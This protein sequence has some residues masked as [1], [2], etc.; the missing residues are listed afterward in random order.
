MISNSENINTGQINADGDVI[1]GGQKVTNI[2]YSNQYKE[3]KSNHEK[4]DRDFEELQLQ[5]SSNPGIDYFTKRLVE[6]DA[7]RSKLQ[8]TITDFEN[9]ILKLAREFMRIPVNTERIKIARSHF[10]NGEYEKARKVLDA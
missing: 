2:Y 1:F 3:L 7:E 5:K 6:I 9:E 4:L 10:F 8:K